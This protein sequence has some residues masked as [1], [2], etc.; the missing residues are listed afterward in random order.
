LQGLQRTQRDI[1]PIADRCGN[2]GQHGIRPLSV[3]ENTPDQSKIR[4]R[5]LRTQINFMRALR[6]GNP[7]L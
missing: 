6:A 3:K 1:L 4:R 7:F 2:D 5:G